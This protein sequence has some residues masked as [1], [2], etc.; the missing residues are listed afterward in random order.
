[1]IAFAVLFICTSFVTKSFCHLTGLPLNFELWHCRMSPCDIFGFLFILTVFLNFKKNEYSIPKV[2]KYVFFFWLCCIP[3]VINAY[4]VENTILSLAIYLYGILI[5]LGVYNVFK[6][7]AKVLF[8]VKII[9]ALLSVLML[10]SFYDLFA[11]YNNLPNI[12]APKIVYKDGQIHEIIRNQVLLGFRNS[13]QLGSFFYFYSL[14]IIPFVFLKKME[15]SNKNLV[16]A[17][18]LLSLIFSIILISYKVTAILSLI[19]SILLLVIFGRNRLSYSRFLVFI[20]SLIVIASIT[21]SINPEIQKQ[22]NYKYRKRIL[23]WFTPDAG[24]KKSTDKFIKR[25]YTKAWNAFKKYPLTG[26][27]LHNF[28]YYDKN[29]VHSTPLKLLS[30]TGL[31]GTLSFLLVIIVFFKE[32]YHHIRSKYGIGLESDYY[33]LLVLLI[34]GSLPSWLYDINLRKREFWLVLAVVLILL[35]LSK[36]FHK[37]KL[38]TNDRT[39]E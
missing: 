36:D 35:S 7:K 24:A 25:N 19:G 6:S 1:M 30:N 12:F 39:E 13:S 18:I 34:I 3:S 37:T 16:I 27:G 29:E 20:G 33:V 14:L 17:L 11:N 2:Y 28:L 10:I 21:L 9:F 23:V 26:V 5:S 4:K 8:L 15:W 38:T 22:I 31:A 32:F